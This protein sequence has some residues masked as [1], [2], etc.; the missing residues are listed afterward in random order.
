[1]SSLVFLPLAAFRG[2]VPRL[3]RIISNRFGYF[4]LS[5]L[6]RQVNE[7]GKLITG[8]AGHAQRWNSPIQAGMPEIRAEA[9]EWALTL[10]AM[11]TSLPAI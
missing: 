7:V 5:Q 2:S 1:V 3:V 11:L 10:S 6:P 4:K 9:I 8:F